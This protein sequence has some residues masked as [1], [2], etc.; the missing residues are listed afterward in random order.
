VPKVTGR[1]EGEAIELLTTAGF[2][3]ATA[4]APRSAAPPGTVV[5]QSP[6]GG[7]APRGSIV[8]IEVTP[9]ALD[10]AEPP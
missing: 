7:S 10:T 6:I 8:T 3:V 1:S 5:V 2:R 9:L 4:P